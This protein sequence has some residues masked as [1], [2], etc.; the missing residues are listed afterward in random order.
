MKALL[1]HVALVWKV[2]S[3]HRDDVTFQVT[4]IGA[5]VFAVRTLVSLMT[6]EN[7]SVPL[8]LLVVGERLRAMATLK[9]QLS[10]VLA[11]YVSL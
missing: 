7:F 2:F 1:T 10:P 9:R 11:L 5:F 8:Q 4:R 3:V 6:L